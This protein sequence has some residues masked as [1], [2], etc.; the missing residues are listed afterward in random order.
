[1]IDLEGWC[2]RSSSDIKFHTLTVLE[3]KPSGLP[4]LASALAAEVPLHYAAPNRVAD[5]LSRLGKPAVAEYIKTKLPQAAKSRSGDLGEI[6]A[7]N[8]VEMKFRPVVGIYKLRWSD[9]REMA[10]RGDDI[11]WVLQPKDSAIMFI[12][13]E[14]KSRAS[15]NK[16]TVDEARA[17][18]VSNDG[19]P[20]PHTLAFLADRLFETG[21]IGFAKTI[22][23]WQL[24]LRIQ[25]SQV[26]HLMFM[27]TGNDPR[28]LLAA[29]L[30]TYGGKIRQFMVGLRVTSHQSF[31]K[32]VFEKVISD[33]D[34]P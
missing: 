6:L 33:G 3:A 22:D 31:I 4:S 28:N 17:A 9:H 5:I 2:K 13:G 29:D 1:M 25:N 19:L 32:Q 15:L 12:K 14:V 24:N 8:Y 18:L 23:N 34:N 10:M 16:K 11:L 20:T 30:N 7:A 26:F 21:Q 27:F